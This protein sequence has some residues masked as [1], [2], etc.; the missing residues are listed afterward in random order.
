M[1]FPVFDSAFDVQLPENLEKS[2]N[3]RQFKEC[4]EKLSEA[5]NSDSGIRE[6]FTDDQIEDIMNGDT[7]EGYVWHHSEDTGKM[8]LVKVEDHDLTRG[9]AAHTGGR[10][11]WGGGY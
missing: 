1:V 3:V 7:P 6:Q 2:S 8:Q 4:N 9:G 5:I 10:A 11:L